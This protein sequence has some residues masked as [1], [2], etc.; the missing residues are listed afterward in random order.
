ME[1]LGK[2]NILQLTYESI[3]CGLYRHIHARNRYHKASM[4]PSEL[5]E[6]FPGRK[7]LKLALWR[8]KQNTKFQ[9]CLPHAQLVSF[10]ELDDGESLDPSHLCHNVAKNQLVSLQ[11]LKTVRM[12]NCLETRGGYIGGWEGACGV[13]DCGA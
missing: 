9:G 7:L 5:Q 2:L 6:Y 12:C 3:T 13:W 11:R 1:G 4:E 10:V 8:S